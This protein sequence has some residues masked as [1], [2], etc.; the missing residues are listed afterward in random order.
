MIVESYLHTLSAEKGCSDHTLRAY[1]RDIERF[2]SFCLENRQEYMPGGT[3]NEEPPGDPDIKG[4]EHIEKKES[5]NLEPVLLSILASSGELLARRFVSG[6][7]HEGKSKRTVARNL[8]SVK[9]DRK[10]V[11]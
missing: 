6:L 2:V 9:S 10:S 4:S 11:V 3:G 5:E 8:S 7:V 1:G